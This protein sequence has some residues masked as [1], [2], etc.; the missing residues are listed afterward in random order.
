[1]VNR[2]GSKQV[3]NVTKI[4]CSDEADGEGQVCKVEAERSLPTRYRNVEE[5]DTDNVKLDNQNVRDGDYSFE[6]PVDCEIV[7]GTEL[8][9]IKCKE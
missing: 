8:N 3:D 1:M 5:V 2:Q 6:E 7:F 4:E 9:R